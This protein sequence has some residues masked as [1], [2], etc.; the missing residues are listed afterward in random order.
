MEKQIKEYLKTIGRKGGT[1]TSA[2]H[3]KD[4]YRRLAEN[5]NR[6]IREKKENNQSPCGSSV[7]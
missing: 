6:K 7:Q 3:G 4:H 1:N 5:M 2:R